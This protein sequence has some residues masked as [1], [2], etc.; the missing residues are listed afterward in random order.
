MGIEPDIYAVKGHYPNQ[1]DDGDIT[2]PPI[3][4][5]HQDRGAVLEKTILFIVKVIA[6][7]LCCA[8]MISLCKKL[9]V[10]KVL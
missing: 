8:C 2:F 3:K 7:C 1:L 6:T 9:R 10:N 4:S 5:Q